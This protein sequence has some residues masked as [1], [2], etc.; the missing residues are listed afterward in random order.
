MK[1]RVPRYEPLDKLLMLPT[2]FRIG[3]GC[4]SGCFWWGFKVEASSTFFAVAGVLLKQRLVEPSTIAEWVTHRK[5]FGNV[6]SPSS[7]KCS[8]PAVESGGLFWE[9]P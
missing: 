1:S 6:T 9:W 8:V 4:E 5:I 2:T 7:V 3:L